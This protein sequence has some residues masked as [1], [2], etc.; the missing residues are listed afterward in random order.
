MIKRNVRKMPNRDLHQDQQTPST[1]TNTYSNR[2]NSNT[3]NYVRSPKWNPPSIIRQ[4]QRL[5]TKQRQRLPS[6]D[7]PPSSLHRNSS[8]RSNSPHRHHHSSRN[9]HHE[10]HYERSESDSRDNDVPRNE[11]H[12]VTRNVRPNNGGRKYF[13][14]QRKKKKARH[15][16]TPLSPTSPKHANKNM[17]FLLI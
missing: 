7:Y 10:D 5:P 3:S 11:Y 8:N 1:S 9:F 16:F 12:G 14:Y 15:R 4:R 2:S 17:D 6:S 13:H